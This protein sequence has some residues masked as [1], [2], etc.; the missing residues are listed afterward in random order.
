MQLRE[1]EPDRDRNVTVVCTVLQAK[2]FE[3]LYALAHLSRSPV[4]GPLMAA[5]KSILDA[6]GD[7]DARVQLIE[8]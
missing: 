4:A 1:W 7:E 6:V 2:G 3:A 8:R 5:F